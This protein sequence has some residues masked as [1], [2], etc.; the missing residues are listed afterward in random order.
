LKKDYKE[1]VS[2]DKLNNSKRIRNEIISK[3]GFVPQ[4][5]LPNM[6]DKHFDDRIVSDIIVEEE[7]SYIEHNYNVRD[8]ALSRFPTKIGI[9]AINFW[10]NPGDRVWDP[11]IGRGQRA[12]ICN[13]LGRDYIGTDV[14][15]KFYNTVVHGIKTRGKRSLGGYKVFVDEDEHFDAELN[16]HRLELL[17]HDAKTAPIEEESC[18][19]VFT[20]YDDK[21]KVLTKRGFKFFKDL[22]Y[23]DLIA[24]LDKNGKLIYQQPID[25]QE[26]NYDGNLISFKNDRRG[27]EL[28][29]TP[30]H[31]MLVRHGLNEEYNLVNADDVNI[32]QRI[33][34]TSDWIGKDKANWILES[35][36]TEKNHTREEIVFD[37]DDWL[38]F[39][40]MFI[41][42]GYTTHN[43]E[44]KG[45]NYVTA[46]TQVK[47]HD[48]LYELKNIMEKYE[49][50]PYIKDNTLC[51]NNKQLYMYLSKLGKAHEKYIPKE[52]LELSKHHLNILF[53]YL[54]LG[55]GNKKKNLYF[56]SS[57]QLRDD[58]VELCLKLGKSI[59]VAKRSENHIS[60]IK[61]RKITAKYTGY[62]ISIG[63][64]HD[65][66]II[67]SK[68]KV[69]YSGK[70]YCCS[71]PNKVLFV[72]R[73]GDTCWCGNSPP[74]WD[75]EFYDDS[76]EQLG[77]GKT[78]E[79]YLDGMREVARTAYKALKPGGFYI[80]A[81]NDFRKGGRFYLLH[82]DLF[83]TMFDVGFVPHDIVIYKISDHPLGAVFASQLEERKV[84][85]KSHEY[86]IIGK[87]PLE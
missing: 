43:C 21:T 41:S 40:G 59:H 35:I 25:I 74:Y 62:I 15:K 31:N 66:L 84:T 12:A 85:A 24:T 53:N 46:I 8:G 3:Y 58:F 28:L 13:M 49:F 70:V 67:K 45:S 26:Y 5:V 65:D 81:I 73:E 18:S 23:N 6:K 4:S 30:N 14:C 1:S 55:D 17:L 9:F 42:D 69:P 36:I 11:C 52:F 47:S 79:E 57:E 64:K 54:I 82:M 20:C 60:A 48:I 56:T 80:L 33:R 27:F 32:G 29:V 37:M 39:L 2:K 77:I 75:I 34:K 76:P 78:Y 16:G 87:R 44:R 10:S 19:L 68:S 38:K 7:A 86:L 72:M 71:V 22:S 83:Q 63:H 61:G 50:N 51:I